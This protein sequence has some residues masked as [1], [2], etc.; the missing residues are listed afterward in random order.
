MCNQIPLKITEN[1]NE[2]KSITRFQIQSA[3]RLNLKKP[4]NGRIKILFKSKSSNDFMK[5]KKCFQILPEL[6]RDTFSM[7]ANFNEN[8]PY[9]EI[10][11]NFQNDT[12]IKMNLNENEHTHDV[13]KYYDEDEKLTKLN[14]CEYPNSNWVDGH[15]K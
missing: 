8:I 4:L 11:I 10:S 5:F 1:C 3:K 13:I 15:Q 6:Y 14:H 9:G 7:I 12:S 2:P